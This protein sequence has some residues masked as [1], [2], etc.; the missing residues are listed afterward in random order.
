MVLNWT[1]VSNVEYWLWC[2][3]GS[4][5]STDSTSV[6]NS[7]GCSYINTNNGN[8]I[9]PPYVVSGLTNASQY[10]FIINGRINGG[11]G[12]TPSP[13]VTASPSPTGV[14][15]VSSRLTN[16]GKLN[17]LAYGATTTLAANVNQFVAVGDNGAVIASGN[18]GSVPAYQGRAWVAANSGIGGSPNLQAV[19]YALGKFITVG[20]GGVIYTSTDAANWSQYTTIDLASHNLNALAAGSVNGVA[21]VVAVGDSGAILLTKDGVS[22]SAAASTPTTANL[23][24][25]TYAISMNLWVAVGAGGAV[26]VSSD[27]SNWRAPDS[28]TAG[29][30]DLRAVTAY[31]FASSGNVVMTNIV[32]VGAGG[33]MLACVKAIAMTNTT[34]CQNA[35]NWSALTSPTTHDLNAITAATAGASQI[36]IVGDNLAYSSPLAT[37]TINWSWR[38][39]AVTGSFRSLVNAAVNNGY[40]NGYVMQWQAVG[41]A[42]ATAYSIN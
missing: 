27:A 20:Q 29:G 9:S 26:W 37:D 33:R 19:T 3:P 13:I 15:W 31:T 11:A 23:Y 6:A 28:Y 10:A 5:V 32:A 16:I 38:A 35:A 34:P 25:V 30:G 39:R 4:V 17:G 14:H 40:N 18:G 21:T 7:G 24:G 2:Q 42:G 22:W 36:V 41:D 8:G 12:G 1:P